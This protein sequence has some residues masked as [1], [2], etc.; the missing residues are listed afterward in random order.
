MTTSR[1][2]S[3]GVGWYWAGQLEAG[4]EL[5]VMNPHD[6][7]VLLSWA[8]PGAVSR[9]GQK[10]HQG[11]PQVVAQWLAVQR[12]QTLE[13]KGHCW[14]SHQQRLP[15]E[16][17]LVKMAPEAEPPQAGP[18]PSACLGAYC[19]SYPGHPQGPLCRLLPQQ[20][21]LSPL[22]GP[23]SSRGLGSYGG[24]SHHGPSST[25]TGPQTKVPPGHVGRVFLCVCQLQ[26]TAAH[27]HPQTRL[28]D[29]L[30]VQ[31][32]SP[33][34]HQELDPEHGQ[35]G[36]PPEGE[37]PAQTSNKTVTHQCSDVAWCCSKR[38]PV[39]DK[40]TSPISGK[41]ARYAQ[42]YVGFD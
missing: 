9:P 7:R 19:V 26:P 23:W 31:Q 29:W 1:R 15:K 3:G 35:G 28:E 42:D 18:P 22:G 20:Q 39:A 30:D 33:V 41:L 38:A 36:S 40:K 27:E 17:R 2:T 37:A 21:E 14:R 11:S 12:F 32:P 13:P 24:L 34:P 4:E 5:A 6:Q 10:K 16:A 8:Q 25:P